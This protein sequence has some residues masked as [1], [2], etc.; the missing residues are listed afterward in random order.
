MPF[1]KHKIIKWIVVA[2]S[3]FGLWIITTRLENKER[4]DAWHKNTD[5]LISEPVKDL[6]T[7]YSQMQPKPPN[8]HGVYEFRNEYRRLKVTFEDGNT[9]VAEYDIVNYAKDADRGS[10]AFVAR[11]K[12]RIM[13]STLVFSDIHPRSESW[14]RYGS[15][16]EAFWAFP[17]AIQ[18]FEM[19][20]DKEI[21]WIRPDVR[22]KLIKQ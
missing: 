7:R 1:Q 8:L 12:Y 11:A 10:V 4:Q 13:G 21:D 5:E 6:L 20:N 17:W 14:L 19:I 3:F 16:S 9:I 22:L 15:D 18:P 2:V